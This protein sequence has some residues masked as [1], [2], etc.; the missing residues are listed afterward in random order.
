ML[1]AEGRR[2]LD[3]LRKFATELGAEDGRIIATNKVVV[4]NRVIL[5]CKYWCEGYGANWS[6]PPFVPSPDEF[7]S[8]LKEY[9]YALV[10]KFK[11]SAKVNE[12]IR[13]LLMNREPHGKRGEELEDFYRIWGE[14]KRKAHRSLLKLE[15]FAFTKG[16]ALALGLRPGSCNL[17]TQCDVKKPCVHPE[18]LRFSP[19]AVGVNLIKTLQN[20]GMSLNFPLWRLGETPS[21]VTMLLIP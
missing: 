10:T 17:C 5:K 9:K 7:R 12:E 3:D 6:C 14:D 11:C 2:V 19:E 13:G 4:E 21:L 1:E 8:I 16:F 15:K 20:A 18:S